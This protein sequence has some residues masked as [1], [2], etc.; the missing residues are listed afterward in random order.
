MAIA[1]SPR[2][3][4]WGDVATLFETPT[5]TE[6][7]NRPQGDGGFN[8]ALNPQRSVS[9]ELGVRARVGRLSLESAIYHTSTRDAIVPYREVG[10][11]TY[12]RNA[13]RTRTSGAEI[14][15]TYRLGKQL[16]V[17][18]TWTLTNA[19]FTDYRVIDGTTT[20]VLDGHR[21]AGVPRE[22]ARLG[23]RG[24][25]GR[26]WQVD[27]D[28]AFTS[29]MFADDDNLIRVD[30]WGAG[31][32]GARLAWEGPLGGARLA[33]FVAAM[34]IFDRRYVGSVSINGAGGRVFEPAPRRTFYVGSEI[35]LSARGSR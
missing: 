6:L 29:A 11:R 9:T 33:P 35:R 12:Y 20:D 34:N 10:G 21:L 15:A 25:I 31:V 14:G 26:G 19:V 28:Q 17:L 16:A 13:G 3:T 27:L 7:A 18:G 32:T 5:T 2:I 23:V 4:A 22:V 24:E 1:L 30:G 8:T